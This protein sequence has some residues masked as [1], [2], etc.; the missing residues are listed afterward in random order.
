M[1]RILRA[2][3]AD[4]NQLPSLGDFEITEG[5]IYRYGERFDTLAD[6]FD[7]YN[8]YTFYLYDDHVSEDRVEYLSQLRNSFDTVSSSTV[9]AALVSNLSLWGS[10]SSYLVKGTVVN[11]IG[12]S[13]FISFRSNGPAQPYNLPLKVQYRGVEFQTFNAELGRLLSELLPK[14]EWRSEANQNDQLLVA[15][16]IYLESLRHA[17]D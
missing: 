12:D 11:E 3:N 6:P 5:D 1:T 15:V 4:P 2:V 13:L 17:E 16:A 10:T 7:L 14:H 9:R 8:D